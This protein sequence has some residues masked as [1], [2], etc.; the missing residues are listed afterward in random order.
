MQQKYITGYELLE[1]QAYYFDV[2]NDATTQK[3]LKVCLLGMQ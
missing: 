2:P 3:F 1:I